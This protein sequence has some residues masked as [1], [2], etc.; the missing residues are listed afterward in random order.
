MAFTCKNLQ[1]FTKIIQQI[2]FPKVRTPPPLDFF[3][4]LT[5]AHVLYSLERAA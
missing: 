2:D 4:A 5:F 1:L 3:L